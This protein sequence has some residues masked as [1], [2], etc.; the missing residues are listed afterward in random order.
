MVLSCLYPAPLSLK[1]SLDIHTTGLYSLSPA[2]F[3]I[4]NVYPVYLCLCSPSPSTLSE[5]NLANSSQRRSSLSSRMPQRSTPMTPPLTDSWTSSRRTSPESSPLLTSSLHQL[6]S[7]IV[8]RLPE[9][10]PQRWSWSTLCVCTRV[11]INVF[12]L[13]E[14]ESNIPC[15]VSGINIFAQR[16]CCSQPQWML[17]VLLCNSGCED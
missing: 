11:V 12:V 14:V 6:W 9:V 1:M 10:S 16:R 3:H 4:T 7:C 8:R 2:S 5:S 13:S 15:T 17:G